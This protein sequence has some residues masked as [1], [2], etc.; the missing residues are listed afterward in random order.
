M[1]QVLAVALAL[2]VFAVSARKPNYDESKVKPYKLED[3][4]TFADGRK[5][6]APEEWAARRLEIL[7]I[8]Q[9][10]MYGRMPP[11]PEN[12]ALEVLEEGKTMDG[13]AV[14]KQVR[15]RFKTGKTGP[16]I[17][18]II[19]RPAHAKKPVPAI[20]FLNYRG[21]QEYFVDSEVRVTDGWIRNNPKKFIENHRAD[22]RSRGAI[23][24]NP[25]GPTTFPLGTILSRGYAVATA[26]Y[27]EISPD[28]QGGREIQDKLAYTGVFSLWPTRDPARTDNTTAL[29]A[30]AWGLMR[31]LDMLE[32]EPAIDAK[33]VV[34][35]GCSRLGKAALIAGAF[36]ERFPVV[37][38]NQTGGGGAPLAKRDFGENVST[39]MRAF[40]HWYCKAYGKYVDN[41]DA[42][43]FDQHLLLA[44][45]APRRLLVE[46]FNQGW[47][48][49]K[50]EY[51]ACR[52]ASCVWKFLGGSP[53][54]DVPYPEDLATDAIGGD[55]GYY[56]RPGNH[57]IN[58][59]DWLRI[60][61]FAD[62]TFAE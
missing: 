46:G 28:P 47:F 54:P 45:V 8:F 39:E 48:D 59:W 3:P 20:L 55:L 44:A 16:K 35:T 49:S 9:R 34:V 57:G 7:E 6:A 52:A 31:G 40:T 19:V 58:D 32:R 61:D 30:W 42:M 60:L 4:L 37:V 2:T 14:R 29:N 25:N 56:H 23:C 15:M 17:D 33:R 24:T 43:P 21:N 22:E 1:K 11:P 38:P 51:L 41:E 27:G 10:E 62:R 36:D 13:F 5:V 18:W 53:M 12:L 50:G 26:C